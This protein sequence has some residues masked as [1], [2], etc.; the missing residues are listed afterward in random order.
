[1]RLLVV[2][3]Y[4]VVSEDVGSKKDGHGKREP[5]HR[6]RNC[7]PTGASIG[8]LLSA[9]PS[10]STLHSYGLHII[11]SLPTHT[12]PTPTEYSCRQPA[13]ID[14]VGTCTSLFHPANALE[15]LCGLLIQIHLCVT[16]MHTL[17]VAVYFC[18]K[19]NDIRVTYPHQPQ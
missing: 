1:M 17:V 6:L 13:T 3:D 10:S 19:V 14:D 8:F 4:R 11:H 2:G 5:K 18:H 15:L 16:Y 9:L 7:L 12:L